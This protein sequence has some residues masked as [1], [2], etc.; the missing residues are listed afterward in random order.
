MNK[1]A[2]LLSCLFLIFCLA[3]VDSL[4]VLAAEQNMLTRNE[5]TGFKKKLV[6]VFNAMGQPPTGYVKEDERFNLPTEV[7]KKDNS[8]KY[9]WV[10][11]SMTSRF[12]GGGEKKAKKS[13]EQLQQEYEKKVA[14]AMAKGN[15]EEMS[16]LAEE[17]QKKIG[18]AHL[19]E[20]EGRKVPIEIQITLNTY[21]SQM[22][23]SD[24]ILF[25]KPGVIALI[26][27]QKDENKNRLIICF[28]PITLK[29]TNILSRMELKQPDG[30]VSNKT[31][32]LNAKIEFTGPGA[33][34]KAW[35]KQIN[36]GGVLSQIDSSH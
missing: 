22:L 8:G 12:S 33:E 36:I 24:M 2:Y 11:P 6:A 14:E 7:Y 35:A 32:V 30:G 15:Y 5:V 3:T 10:T 19:A 28:D 34:I 17:M 18:E 31:A 16:K 1:F 23:D 20:V 26:V 21:E 29:E 4:T 9:E 27:N 25:E 13:Q